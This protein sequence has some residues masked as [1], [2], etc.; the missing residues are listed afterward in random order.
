MQAGGWR[1]GCDDVLSQHRGRQI[2][3]KTTLWRPSFKV[4]LYHRVLG[5]ITGKFVNVTFL[6]LVLLQMPEQNI[7]LVSGFSGAANN[8]KKCG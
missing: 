2:A 8:F 7:L 1:M 6:V 3:P 5:K 4:A